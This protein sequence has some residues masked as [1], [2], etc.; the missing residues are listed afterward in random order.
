MPI[1]LFTHFEF[2]KKW[3]FQYLAKKLFK[4]FLKNFN[5]FSYSR[6]IWKIGNQKKNKFLGENRR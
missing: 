1:D 6:V 5:I 2:K 4:Y 3:F